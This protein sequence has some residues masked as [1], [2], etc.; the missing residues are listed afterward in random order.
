MMAEF[1]PEAEEEMIEAAVFYQE[2][3]D[4][5]GERFLDDMEQKPWVTFHP[6]SP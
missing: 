2:Q 3:A 1:L 5:L 4:G 6:F